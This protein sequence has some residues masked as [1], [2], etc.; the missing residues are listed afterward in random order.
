MK[1]I[2][3]KD[4]KV[5]EKN[6]QFINLILRFMLTLI[7]LILAFIVYQFFTQ[8]FD[9][10]KLTTLQ[11]H[12]YKEAKDAPPNFLGGKDLEYAENLEQCP[13][14]Y[15][16]ININSG[17]KR[18]PDGDHQLVY[19]SLE[20]ACTR[21]FTCDFE[22]LPYAVNTDGS[23]NKKG[24]CEKNVPCRCSRGKNCNSSVVS[25]FQLEFSSDPNDPDK[26][27]FVIGQ[28]NFQIEQF[29]YTPITINDSSTEF[30][31]INPGFTE[32]VEF[33]CDFRNSLN[34]KLGCQYITTVQE[35]SVESNN[36]I[37]AAKLKS[38]I[39]I[40]DKSFSSYLFDL[41]G[42]KKTLAGAD[43]SD[44]FYYSLAQG[45]QNGYLEFSNSNSSLIEY[46]AYFKFTV[47][48]HSN[49]LIVSEII[50]LQTIENGK[51]VND[52]AYPYGFKGNW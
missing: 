42:I 41:A 45:T 43:E 28:N 31:Q 32:K 36:T 17:I 18:C 14:G 4:K 37:E 47:T 11:Y 13:S 29:G 51:V 23:T 26:N 10:T 39:K 33:G 38:D 46:V 7:I 20:E 3:K 49:E 27:N 30:C 25:T 40:G 5:S 52:P 8:N 50:H 48:T 12:Y 22:G 19:Y 16:A 9:P 34:D 24:I 1:K 15:C 35:I 21:K 6:Y 44:K 2:K